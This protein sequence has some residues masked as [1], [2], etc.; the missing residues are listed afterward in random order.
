MDYNYKRKDVPVRQLDGSFKRKP[1]YAKTDKEL[2]AKIN[3]VQEEAEQDYQLH[4]CPLFETVADE[5]NEKHYDE[6]A[7]N[8]WSGYQRPLKDLKA[9]FKGLHITEITFQMLQGLL[10]RMKAQGFARQTINLRKVTASLVFEYAVLMGYLDN[11]P[12]LM[13]KV[14]RNAPHKPRSLPEAEEID[15]MLKAEGQFGDLARFLYYT[16][17]RLGEALALTTGDIKDGYIHINK[18]LYWVTINPHIK[19][20]PKTA[21]SVRDIPVLKPIEAFLRNRKGIIF[22]SPKGGYMTKSDYQKGW[23][24]FLTDNDIHLTAH[25]LRHGF[26]TLCFDANLDEKDAAEL[27]G[28]SSITLTKDIYTHITSARK[29]INAEKLN[30]FLTQN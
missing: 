17:C 13:L 21:S 10:D 2:K 15:K 28:H 19:D 3:K 18:S 24:K 11:S 12:A 16:G 5:W 29:K 8:T 23:N 7:Y 25:Q 4:L 14:P 6:I 30:E 22:P 1:I 20:S 27:L 26:A 9:E